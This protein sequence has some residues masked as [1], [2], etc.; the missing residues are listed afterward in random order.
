MQGLFGASE[1]VFSEADFYLPKGTWRDLMA[2]EIQLFAISLV[3]VFLGAVVFG[4][5]H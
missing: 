5:I 2:R 4:I 3:F 1:Y